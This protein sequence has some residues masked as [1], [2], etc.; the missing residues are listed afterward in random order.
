MTQNEPNLEKSNNQIPGQM[1][2]D[3]VCTCTMCSHGLVRDCLKVRCTCCKEAS[4]SMILDGM[5][6]FP[7]TTNNIH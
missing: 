1:P 4:H 5:Q 6:G 3:S 7:P 2:F